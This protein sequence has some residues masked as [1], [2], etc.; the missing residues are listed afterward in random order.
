MDADHAQH[1]FR[2][3]IQNV[4]ITL[5]SYHTVAVDGE[6]MF[7]YAIW[8]WIEECFSKTIFNCLFNL[9][10]HISW[11]SQQ[12]GTLVRVLAIWVLDSTIVPWPV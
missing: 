5:H 3:Q 8:N 7:C 9:N 10:D 2:D 6:G 11:R 12:Y 4:K 1:P